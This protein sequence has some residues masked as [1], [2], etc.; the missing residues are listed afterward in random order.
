MSS[1]K[2][3]LLSKYNF[4]ITKKHYDQVRAQ[5]VAFELRDS[6]PL[7]LNSALLGVEKIH[8]FTSDYVVL[9]DIFNVEK[10]EFEKLTHQADEIDPE[11]KVASDPYNLLTIWAAHLVMKSSLSRSLKEDFLFNLF[12]LMIYKFYTSVVNHSLS[13]GADRDVMEATIDN[14]SAK[15]DIKQR[16]TKTW[17]LVIEASARAIYDRKSVHYTRLETFSKVKNQNVTYIITDAQTRIRIKLR[18]IINMY[19]TN[20]EKGVRIGSVG[21]VD[22]ING[23]KVI[24]NIVS[25][26]DVMV[27]N[28]SNRALNVNR[29]IS[30]DDIKLVVKLTKN[31]RADHFK[32]LLITFSDVAVQQ[33]RKGDQYEIIGKGNFQIIKG[34]REFI[35]W[36]I[37]KTYRSAIM[38]G[39]VNMN[40]R[41]EILEKTRNLYRSSR[42]SDNDILIIKNS[43]EDFVNNHSDSRRTS[44][45]TSLKIALITYIIVLSFKSL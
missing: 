42:I 20:K 5:C 30:R 7:A 18:N 14:L 9:F 37:Q 40:S 43:A 1:L 23:E 3:L 31:V 8:F 12:K 29:W 36:V 39:D 21:I 19:Y 26:F 45:N 34:Y 44:S 11:F 17:K 38:A 33:T 4:T 2:Q 24:N 22:E 16:E 13:H 25:N 41:L 15:Y 6:N 32:S 28:I 10:T 35:T 27:E